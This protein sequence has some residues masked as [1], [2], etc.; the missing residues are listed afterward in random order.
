MKDDVERSKNR[1]HLDLRVPIEV[2]RQAV[3]R[4]LA[5]GA[6]RADDVYL[7]DQFQVMRDPAQNEFCL[8]WN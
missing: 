4:A 5:L 1:V 7:G 8:I 3:E 6:T 2:R